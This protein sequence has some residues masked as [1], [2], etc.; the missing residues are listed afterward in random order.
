M[1]VKRPLWWRQRVGLCVGDVL[2]ALDGYRIANKDQY[3]IVR[4]MNGEPDIMYTVWRSSK[5][6]ERVPG[7]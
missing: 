3:S 7:R 6:L 4:D 5:Y 2:V 1:R